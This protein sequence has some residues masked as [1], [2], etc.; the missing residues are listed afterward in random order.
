MTH[1]EI[2]KL[3]VENGIDFVVIGGVALR[4][5]NS[6][7]TTHDIDIAARTL[8]ID[9]IISLMYRNSYYLVTSVDEDSVSIALTAEKATHWPEQTKSGSISFVLLHTVPDRNCVPMKHIDVSS[10]VDVLFELGVPIM[11]LKENAQVVTLQDFSFRVASIED[12]IR[13]KEQRSDRTQT[14]EEDIRFLKSL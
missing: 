1:K 12:L 9:T 6:P 2:L 7:R 8:D 5:Y 11:R 4:L 13:L 10:Q 3:L 14:D